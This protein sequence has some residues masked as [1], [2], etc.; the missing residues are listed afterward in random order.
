MRSPIVQEAYLGKAPEKAGPETVIT[1][2]AHD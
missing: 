1:E 2:T